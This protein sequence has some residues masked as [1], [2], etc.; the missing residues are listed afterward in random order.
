MIV[1]ALGIVF[2]LAC[3]VA[4]ATIGIQV[5]VVL[6]ILLARVALFLVQIVMALGWCVWFCFRPGLAMEDLRRR[7]AK[8][9]ADA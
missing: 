1:W 9:A 4:A 8:D 5:A 2:V 7:R 3:L 6:L